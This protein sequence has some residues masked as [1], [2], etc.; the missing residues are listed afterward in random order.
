LAE[1]IGGQVLWVW[2]LPLFPLLGPNEGTFIAA[3]HRVEAMQEL[4]YDLTQHRSKSLA[5]LANVDFDVAVR[6]EPAL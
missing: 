4:G 2:D 6:R 5:E 1:L 3:S